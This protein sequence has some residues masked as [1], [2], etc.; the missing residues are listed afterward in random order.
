MI[1]PCP[2]HSERE[3]LLAYAKEHSKEQV[4]IE[5]I[6]RM[7]SGLPFSAGERVSSLRKEEP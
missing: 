4:A 1:R 7:F 3:L 5:E 2:R 6:H